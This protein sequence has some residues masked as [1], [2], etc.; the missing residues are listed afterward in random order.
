MNDSDWNNVIIS[1]QPEGLADA[2]AFV[3]WLLENKPC[4][5]GTDAAA[6]KYA[7]CQCFDTF[8]WGMRI[9]E[10]W[11]WADKT[12]VDEKDLRS[13]L[14][15]TL[16]EARVFG[17]TEETLVWRDEKPGSAAFHGRVVKNANGGAYLQR[18]AAF[19]P[20][21]DNDAPPTGVVERGSVR[22]TQHPDFVRRE[23]GN[24]RITV[25]P[26]GSGVLVYEYLQ[27]QKDT[28]AVR[29]FLTRFVDIEPQELQENNAQ[30]TLA[31]QSG[32]EGTAL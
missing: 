15:R 1:V 18:R 2:D 22:A 5:G 6:Y 7:V 8:V 19:Q 27:E 25:T 10:T 21:C 12:T 30:D 29:I 4:P 23:L 17:P 20:A 11:V 26:K 9:G 13:P 3:S 16:L 31:S 28:G 24:G 32:T 14:V